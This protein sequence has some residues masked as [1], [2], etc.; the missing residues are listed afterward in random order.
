MNALI[1]PRRQSTVKWGVIVLAFML[2]QMG[3]VLA[4]D[5][6]DVAMAGDIPGKNIQGECLPFAQELYH[7][8]TRVGSETHLI[9]YD[10]CDWEGRRGVHA[11]VVYQDA[12]KR[13]WA[14]DNEH[15]RPVWLDGSSAQAWCRSFSPY[16]ANHVRTNRTY[17]PGMERT[18]NHSITHA[19]RSPVTPS[20][21][22]RKHEHHSTV[23]GI[24]SNPTLVMIDRFS[25]VQSGMPV[26]F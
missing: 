21:S 7:R 11:I 23:P 24:N 17:V 15:A 19:S 9:I 2:G 14:M 16:T 4:I 25:E 18:P 26:A 3:R 10:W 12:E 6:F 20:P 8:L 5:D 22:A 1:S 13:Y